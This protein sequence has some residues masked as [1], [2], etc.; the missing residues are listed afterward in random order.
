MLILILLTHVLSLSSGYY[1]TN[2]HNIVDSN[3]NIVQLV[4]VNAFGYEDDGCFKSRGYYNFSVLINDTNNLGFNTWRIP[5]SAEI[6]HRWFEGDGS[7]DNGN[8]PYQDYKGFDRNVN[9][10]WVKP[11]GKDFG[12]KEILDWFVAEVGKYNHKIIFDVHSLRPGSYRDNLWYDEERSPV[13]IYKALEFLAENFSDRD[14]VIGI[15][16]K[17][18]PHG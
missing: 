12:N 11:N 7:T 3:E 2:G 4:G 6:V 18:E 15:D 16:I 17:N 5:V 13:Y 8:D 14:T 10:A 1:H 9:P